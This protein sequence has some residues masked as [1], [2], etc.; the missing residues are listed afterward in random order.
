[1]ESPPPAERP[2]VPDTPRALLETARLAAD[3][4]A[5]VHLRWAHRVT[6]GEAVD[7]GRSDFVTR[8]DREAQDAALSVI[9]RRHPAHRI[10]AEEEVEEDGGGGVTRWSG[11]GDEG[12]PLWIVDPLDGTTNFLHGHPMYA[13]SVGV[14]VDGRPVA[15]A[16][17]APATGERWWAAQGQGAWRDGRP[18]RV[19][20]TGELRLALVGTGFPFKRPDRI[21]HYLGQFGRVLRHTSGIRRGG[22][23]ALDL[24]YLAQGTLD[25][26][27]EEHLSPWDVAGGLAILAEAGGIWMRQDGS[28]LA[29]HEGGTVLAANGP[30][31]LAALRDVLATGE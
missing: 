18:I 22:A 20:G 4:A 12:Q 26:F 19:S 25:A 5:A 13:A 28:A 24:C 11:E 31:L 14:A 1:M 17:T 21:P 3:A 2:L 9:R 10:L 7:K 29:L 27:W 8:V 6:P 15:G 30:E 16:V 23:A